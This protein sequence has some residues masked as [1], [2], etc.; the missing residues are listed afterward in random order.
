MLKI[1]KWFSEK[2]KHQK[3]KF[4]YRSSS[5]PFSPPAPNFLHRVLAVSQWSWKGALE[6]LDSASEEEKNTTWA[7]SS[8]DWLRMGQQSRMGESM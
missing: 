7:Y 1:Q 5:L 2:K 3:V 8:S 4:A 6:D